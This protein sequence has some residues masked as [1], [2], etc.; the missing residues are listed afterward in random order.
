MKFDEVLYRLPTSAPGR[1]EVAYIKKACVLWTKARGKD[2]TRCLI[3][4]YNGFRFI[5]HSISG[6]KCIETHQR[7]VKKNDGSGMGIENNFKSEYYNK[8][9]NIIGT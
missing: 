3:T 9:M 7:N 2:A 1:N 4:K 5:L 6:K 8:D